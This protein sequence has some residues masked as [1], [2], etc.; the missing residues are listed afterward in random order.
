MIHSRDQLQELAIETL[1]ARENNEF[2]YWHRLTE[3]SQRT[4][5]PQDVR[6][7][8]ILFMANGIF[9]PTSGAAA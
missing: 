1:K 3:L 8:R 5:L 6:E 4:G 2:E 7:M 9:E